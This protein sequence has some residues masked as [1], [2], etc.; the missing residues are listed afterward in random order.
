MDLSKKLLPLAIYVFTVTI[1]TLKHAV[2][3]TVTN[4]D[5]HTHSS[6]GMHF[7]WKRKSQ[8]KITSLAEAE[9]SAH[10]L[11]TIP[12]SLILEF[13]TATTAFPDENNCS[14]AGFGDREQRTGRRNNVLGAWL[15]LHG[16][17]CK[18]F[19]I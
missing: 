17:F 1:V 9:I 2:D 5:S 4:N 15:L 14:L 18:C 8:D 7:L 3:L 6:I 13:S 16:R 19:M 10:M 12:S 11:G